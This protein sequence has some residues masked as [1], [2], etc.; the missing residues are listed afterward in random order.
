MSD[1]VNEVQVQEL[2]HVYLEHSHLEY[3]TMSL[4]CVSKA[5]SADNTESY[6]QTAKS[7]WEQGL[8][9]SKQAAADTHHVS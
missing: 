2:G 9:K 7:E 6:L 3:I 5:K 8:F 1:V 4:A